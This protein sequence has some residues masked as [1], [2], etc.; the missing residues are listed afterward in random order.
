MRVQE[1]SDSFLKTA[2]APWTEL[3]ELAENCKII[4]NSRLLPPL[5]TSTETNGY[6]NK[7]MNSQ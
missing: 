6:E 1:N 2:T 3:S 7:G 5:P 4:R